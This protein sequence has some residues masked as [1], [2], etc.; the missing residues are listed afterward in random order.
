MKWLQLSSCDSQQAQLYDRLYNTQLNECATEYTIQISSSYERL[1][2]GQTD[3][4][5]NINTYPIDSAFPFVKQ[6][7]II[8]TSLQTSSDTLA[9]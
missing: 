5:A 7:Q 6:S 1:T 9:L 3:S 8:V 4:K 2:G